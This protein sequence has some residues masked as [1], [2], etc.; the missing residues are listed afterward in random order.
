MIQATML[1]DV[2]NEEKFAL[3]VMG[4]GVQ[5]WAFGKNPITIN[6]TKSM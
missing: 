1:L 2:S 5:E 6:A 3:V 4:H